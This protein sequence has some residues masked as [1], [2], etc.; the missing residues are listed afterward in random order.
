V[1][2]A[3][4]ASLS[5]AGLAGCIVGLLLVTASPAHAEWQF[6][7]FLGYTFNG[8]TTLIDFGLVNNQ[9]ANDEPHIDFG[10]SVALLGAGPIGIEGYFVHT[11]NFFESKQF[12]IF[13]PRTLGSRTYS[14]MGNVV[15]T[16]PRSWNR[17]GLRPMLSGGA[18][19]IH[20]AVEDQGA[21]LGYRLNLWGVNVGGGAVGY[22]SDRVG[23]RFDLRYFQNISG[24]PDEQLPALT[25][26]APLRLRYWTATFGVVFKK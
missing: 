13:L 16:I 20:A 1:N 3:A 9:T 22:L 2:L 24:V 25:L 10:G 23:V 11:P 15:L 19:L 4:R 14:M 17:Y 8:S 18:G 12:N 26:G 7:P 6:T 21:V 5:C